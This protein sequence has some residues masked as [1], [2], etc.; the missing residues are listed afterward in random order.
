MTSVRTLCRAMNPANAQLKS[1]RKSP[2]RALVLWLLAVAASAFLLPETAWA[3]EGPEYSYVDLVMLYELAPEGQEEEVRYTVR[4]YG[5]ATAVGVTVSFLLEDLEARDFEDSDTAPAAI[6]DIRTEDGTNQ[7]ITW[8]VGDIPPGTSDSM[9]FDTKI[10]PGR[11]SEIVSG[12]RGRIGVINATASSLS[13]EP[14]MLLANN[15]VKVYA[16]AAESW[17]T[18]HMRGSTLALLLS[19]DDLRPD[20]GGDVNFG[21]TAQ[22]IAPMGGAS[23]LPLTPSIS[24]A[25][26]RNPGGTI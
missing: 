21:L 13:P 8:E 15:N 19:V 14:G 9:S 25:D 20:A 24:S 26:I 3:Q 17:R 18:F 10:H 23:K 11:L 22:H 7:R 6:T 4:N 5:T 2:W 16:F 1:T 12:W